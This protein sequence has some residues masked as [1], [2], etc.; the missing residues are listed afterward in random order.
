MRL[1]V[2]LKSR[3]MEEVIGCVKR[4][5]CWE[6]SFF[7]SSDLMCKIHKQALYSR[8]YYRPS[9]EATNTGR[10]QKW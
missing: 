1:L 2:S 8:T 4:G 9:M 7:S 3:R 5:K 6:I 10:D